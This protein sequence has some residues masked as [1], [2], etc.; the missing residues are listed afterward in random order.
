MA[1]RK[2]RMGMIGGGPGA[3]IGAVHRIAAY[4][5]TPTGHDWKSL[6][7]VPAMIAGAILLLFLIFFKDPK[8]QDVVKQ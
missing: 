4:Y 7:M 2:L 8:K 1:K 6:W 3:F 5:K